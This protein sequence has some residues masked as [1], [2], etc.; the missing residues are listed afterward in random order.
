VPVN[1]EADLAAV[2]QRLDELRQRIAD[3]LA[4][5][6]PDAAEEDRTEIT[7]LAF[8]IPSQIFQRRNLWGLELK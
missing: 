3:A 5:L 2:N 7:D 4:V 6:L 8:E 1:K